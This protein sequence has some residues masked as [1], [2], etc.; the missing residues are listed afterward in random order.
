M[1]VQRAAKP[2]QVGATRAS[3]LPRGPRHERTASVSRRAQVRAPAAW[4]GVTHSWS[5][6]PPRLPFSTLQS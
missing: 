4:R 6:G 1:H 2:F 3:S 5:Q